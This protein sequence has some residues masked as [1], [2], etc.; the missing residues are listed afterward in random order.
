MASFPKKIKNSFSKKMKSLSDWII[1]NSTYIC[2]SFMFVFGSL[3]MVFIC[4]GMVNPYLI[5]GCII[6]SIV[7]PS[8]I[9]L[10]LSFYILIFKS[11][12]WADFFQILFSMI[13]FV[14]ASIF[15]I[16]CFIRKIS[17]FL[18]QTGANFSIFE[19]MGRIR[20]CFA[21]TS[22]TTTTQQ[23]TPSSYLHNSYQQIKNPDSITTPTL[24]LPPVNLPPMNTPPV[25]LPPMNT[26]LVN[27]PPTNTP[28]VNLP[29]TNT[30]PVITSPVNSLP[31]E[32]TSNPI[33]TFA[34]N[35][36]VQARAR[37]PR[38]AFPQPPYT[39]ITQN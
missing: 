23:L 2:L 22:Y 8:L 18:G 33:K 20:E 36:P 4:L 28:L 5:G 14:V 29:P 35:V 6:G 10:F 27:L 7:I 38:N 17:S 1:L 39:K 30:L 25:N 31:I 26:P 16:K 3:L 34:E 15:G 37:I 12:T 11:K 13:F 9:F 24:N 19:L 21:N 32:P